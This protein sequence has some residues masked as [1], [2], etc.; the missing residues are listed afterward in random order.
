MTL[1]IAIGVLALVNLTIKAAGPTLLGD[2]QLPEWSRGVIAL[3]AAALLTGLVVVN[4][5]GAG[6]ASFRW[7]VVIGL[8]VAVG[9]R[10][11]KAPVLPAVLAGVVTTALLRLAIG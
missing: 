5:V 9:A 6:G 4:V 10:L 8:A 11:L 2:R 7:F 3:L 1:W